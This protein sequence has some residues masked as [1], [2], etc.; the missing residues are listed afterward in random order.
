VL[1]PGTVSHGFWWDSLRL[2]AKSKHG[3]RSPD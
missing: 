3:T 2:V 1:A